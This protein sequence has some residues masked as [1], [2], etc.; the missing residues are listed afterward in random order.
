ML[1]N[2]VNVIKLP[3][4][5]KNVLN[6][7]TSASKNIDDDVNIS[8]EEGIGD[9]STFEETTLRLLYIETT[10][11]KVF[12]CATFT[13]AFFGVVGNLATICKIIRDPKF[14]TPTFAAIGLL[15][16]ADFLSVT[17]LSFM[18]LTINLFDILTFDINL[19]GYFISNIV[20]LSSYL[21][22]C[23]LC[24]V[25]YLITVYPL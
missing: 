2:L 4:K 22:V 12:A 11:E 13:I 19:F 3:I 14:H 24:A 23:L 7:T 25:R 17:F 6:I 20:Y 21:H 16:S 9:D 10:F 5:N 18:N 15:A 1:T 8:I